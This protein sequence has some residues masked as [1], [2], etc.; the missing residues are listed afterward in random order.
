[1][2]VG[3]DHLVIA[4]ATL[5]D[6]V[7]W[8]ESTLGVTPGPGGKHPLMGTHNR[9]LRLFGDEFPA[10]FLEIIAIDPD[11][12]Q[13]PHARWFGLDRRPRAAAPALVHWVARCDLIVQ[14]CETLAGLGLDPGVPTAVSR[15][16]PQGRLAWIFSVRADGV[17][18][19]AGALPALIEWQ[20]PHPTEHMPPSGLRLESL[21][22]GG[23]PRNASDQLAVPGVSFAGPPGLRA[24][25]R[26]PQGLM[27]LETAA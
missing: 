18:Q 10:A 5:E 6:G 17:P 21:Q 25:L 19:A 20:G 16:T 26:G 11:A 24:T 23:L 9:L 15:D 7:R 12:A 8:C 1:M 13:P 4:A 27:T 14:R 3:L 22:V 2:S